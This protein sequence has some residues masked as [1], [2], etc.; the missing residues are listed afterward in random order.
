[1][2][3]VDV[4]LG[5]REYAIHI[6]SGVLQNLANAMQTLPTGRRLLLITNP[7]VQKLFGKTLQDALEG[8]GYEVIVGEVPEG[9]EFKT[10]SQA[11]VLYD[12]AFTHGL[13]RQSLV[14]ALGGGVIGDLAGFVAATYMRGVPFVQI[15][16][17][18]LAQ[19]D[20]SV[21]GKVAVNHPA[22][23]NI[24]GAFYQPLAVFSDL[25]TL[26]T[27]D[28]REIRGG[29][30]EVIK[31]GVI[32][33]RVFFQWLEEHMEQVLQLE[34]KALEYVVEKSCSIKAQVVQEDETEQGRRAILNF[35]HTIGHAVETLTGYTAYRHGEAVSIG[36]VLAARLAVRMGFLTAD[37]ALRIEQVLTKASLPVALPKGLEKRK[38]LDLLRHDKKVI[39]DSLTFVLPTDIGSVC[40]EKDVPESEIIQVLL[41]GEN[42]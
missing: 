35:G 36:M 31:Y 37:K 11:A 20:S 33:D 38:I 13:D 17:T 10:L 19:V 16:T 29:L 42:K 5:T 21:G 9:E 25:D 23:K 22:G 2:A 26:S 15:P 39:S 41:A 12:L 28:A 30:A 4:D 27:L 6:G 14:V 7:V 34:P 3:R 1:M 8:V 24:I 32:A 18:L 40:L